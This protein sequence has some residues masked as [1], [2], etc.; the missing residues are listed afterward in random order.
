MALR[1]IASGDLQLIICEPDREQLAVLDLCGGH[2]DAPISLLHDGI[3]A[4]QGC[5]GR[6][7]DKPGLDVGDIGTVPPNAGSDGHVGTLSQA[8]YLLL[9]PV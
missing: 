9:A 2:Y 3:P 5:G 8:E 6:Q 4:P 1:T 7:R